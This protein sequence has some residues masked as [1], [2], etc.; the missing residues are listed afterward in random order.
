MRAADDMRYC[1]AK[2]LDRMH[3]VLT[4][5]GDFTLDKEMREAV[6]AALRPILQ[7]RID[8]GRPVRGGGG[9]PE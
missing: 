3:T 8:T 4:D 6:E 7:R 2:Q 9:V 5:Y 1:M